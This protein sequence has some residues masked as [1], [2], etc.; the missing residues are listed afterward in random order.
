MLSDSSGAM[1]FALWSTSRQSHQLY[2]ALKT[3]VTQ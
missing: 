3:R 2:P 1:A